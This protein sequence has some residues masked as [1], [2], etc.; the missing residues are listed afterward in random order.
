MLKI[1]NFKGSLPALKPYAE[2][3]A[4]TECVMNVGKAISDL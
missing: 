3:L 2:E 4:T 1:Q